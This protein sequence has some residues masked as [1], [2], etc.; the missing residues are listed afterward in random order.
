MKV[1]IYAEYYLPL[2]FQSVMSA[3]PLL[4]GVLLLPL[5]V[6][7]AV[8]GIVA[9]VLIHRTGR[10]RE[11][12]WVGT[13]TLCLANGLFI[14]VNAHT[15]IAKVIGFELLLGFGSGLLFEAPI[16]AIQTVAKQQDVATATSTYTFIRSMA[17]AMAVVIGGLVFQN[18]M[19]KQS[20]SLA[21]AGLSAD[22]LRQFSGSEAAANV[23]LIAKIPVPAQKWA[24]KAAFAW[25]MRNMW[26][27]NTAIGFL[28]VVAGAFIQAAVL[29]HTHEETVTGIREKRAATDAEQ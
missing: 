23:Q 16:I 4:S 9:G 6:C 29:H 17:L 2:F 12:I 25:A 3:T 11:L 10:F 26:I 21:H 18:G 19:S 24:V 15:S 20:S 7:M 8:S 1:F 13:T 14:S 27:M 22:L 28:G 5:I